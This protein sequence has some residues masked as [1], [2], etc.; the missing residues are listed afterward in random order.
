MGVSQSRVRVATMFAAGVI[1][2]IA[3][4]LAGQWAYAPLCGWD[5]AAIVF[6]LCVWLAVGRMNSSA[7]ATHATCENPGRASGDVIVL[8]AAI[9]SLGAVSIAPVRANSSHGLAQD[10]RHSR[11]RQPGAV[12]V[13]RPYPWKFGSGPVIIRRRSWC[14]PIVTRR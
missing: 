10:M 14:K 3:V 1:A 4:G 13:D 9:A 8:I 2:G 5:F 6:T 12:L 11:C 7:T